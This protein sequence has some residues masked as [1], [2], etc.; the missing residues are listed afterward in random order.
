VQGL[1][2]GLGNPSVAVIPEFGGNPKFVAFYR[3]AI[4]DFTKDLSNLRLV[5]IDRG[6]VDMPI[7]AGN[8][9]P[10]RFGYLFSREPV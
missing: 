2:A 7:T 9:P 6:T 1:P 4:E 10:D 3:P 5:L 8:R